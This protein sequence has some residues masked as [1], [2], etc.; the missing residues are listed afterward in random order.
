VVDK[1]RRRRAADEVSKT[2]AAELAACPETARGG[3]PDGQ[4]AER[5]MSTEHPQ[6]HEV[7][8]VDAM[9]AAI[10]D[11]ARA[12]ERL[13]VAMSGAAR[14]GEVRAKAPRRHAVRRAY[15][16]TGTVSDTDKQAARELLRRAGMIERKP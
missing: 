1:N 2:E 15:K 14:S 6:P 7:R 16:P 8:A 9:S 4:T 5:P 12:L 11:V 13:A 3:S 10:L